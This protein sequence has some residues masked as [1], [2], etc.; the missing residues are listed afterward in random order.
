V[1][2][3]TSVTRASHPF[4]DHGQPDTLRHPPGNAGEVAVRIVLERLTLA[5]RDD[6]EDACQVNRPIAR[7]VGHRISVVAAG[8]VA[9]SDADLGSGGGSSRD[10]VGVGVDD[11]DRQVGDDVFLGDGAVGQG[12]DVARLDL[13]DA[14]EVK[15][16]I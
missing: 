16:E 11:S 12:D 1:S 8:W 14:S 13:K 7:S 3:A 2:Q 10:G 4:K 15:M 6:V 5:T 9:G